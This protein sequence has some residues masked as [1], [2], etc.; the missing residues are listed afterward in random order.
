MFWENKGWINEINL[1]GWF[2]CYFRYWL[3]RRSKTMKDKSIDGKKLK[4][5]L[6]VNQLR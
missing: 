5:D 4:V 3:G 6:E 2:Q 1:Y